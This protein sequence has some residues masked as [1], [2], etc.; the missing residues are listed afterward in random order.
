MLNPEYVVGLV[1]GEGSFY[2]RL[3]TD[4]RRRNKVEM[5]FS[6]KLRYQD[7]EIL[8]QLKQFFNCGKVYLQKDNRPNHTDCYRFEVNNRKDIIEKIIFFF[9]NNSPKIQSRKRDFELFKRIAELSQEEVLDMNLIQNLKEKMHWGLAV[10]G[11]TVCTV[12]T[13][14]NSIMSEKQCPS[15]QPSFASMRPVRDESL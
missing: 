5:K 14:S 10:Y 8:E 9:D 1:D 3:N 13:S 6:V 11:K 7:K 15:N 12:E 4:Q 2:V